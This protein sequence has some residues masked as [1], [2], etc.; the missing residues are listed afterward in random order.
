MPEKYTSEQ[1]SA[2]LADLPEWSADGDTINRSFKFRNH[3][4][5]MGFVVRVAIVAEV[6]NHHPDLRIVYNQVQLRLSSHDVGGVTDRDT[7]LAR[8]V[9]AL[10]EG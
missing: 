6:L 9:D 1:I 8:R 10:V 2:A 4:E 7:E 5:A 3:V